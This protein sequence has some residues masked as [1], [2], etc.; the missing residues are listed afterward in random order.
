MAWYNITYACGHEGREQIY[1][2]TKNRQWI[3]D[4]KAEGLCPDCYQKELK[5]KHE[6]ENAKA[7]EVN[8]E[9]GLPEL[10]GTPKQVAWAETCR[11]DLIAKI[12][13]VIDEELEHIDESKK[14]VPLKRLTIALQHIMSQE[15]AA[16]WIDN[17]GLEGRYEIVSLLAKHYKE[18]N[19]EPEK[20]LIEAEKIAIEAEA[21]VRPENPVTETVAEILVK[22]DSV[23]IV[24]PEKRD[25]FRELVKSTLKMKWEGRW[26]RKLV[27]RN[28]T[29]VDRAAEAG[30]RLLAA[31]FPIRIFDAA[32]REKA[33]RGEYEPECTRWILTRTSGE[34]NGWLVVSW[35]C[36]DD[37]YKAARRLPGSRYSSPCVV[38]RPEHY[39]EVL[40]FA[41][42]Y[43]FKI[44][45]SAQAFI[46]AAREI[47]ERALVPHIDEPE[48]V[49]HIVTSGK[50]PVLE[51]PS[52]VGIADEFKD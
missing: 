12:Q 13:K 8:K 36:P 14:D 11:R 6:E 32:I 31:G 10:I 42:K 40:D 48:K 33:I 28:G 16:W 35:E 20:K 30:H 38:V 17:R 9:Y 7:A 43:G 49:K 27:P 26:V 46:D 45:A 41:A 44:S 25:D 23:E 3:A 29:P 19:S 37:F 18:A 39:E 2:P 4:R 51:V 50:P 52:E 22:D 1:G 24:F 47:R 5:R 21:T 15:S 34:Y